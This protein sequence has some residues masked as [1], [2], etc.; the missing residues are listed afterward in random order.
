MHVNNSP[1]ALNNSPVECYASPEVIE[2]VLLKK[3]YMFTKI[4]NNDSVRLRELGDL[5]MEILSAKQDGYLPGLAFLDT[6]RGISPI[7]AKLSHSL[8]EKWVVQGSKFKADHNGLFPPFSFFAEFIC[9]EAR[10]RNDPS[11]TLRDINSKERPILRMMRVSLSPLKTSVV[12]DMRVENLER[13]CPIHNRPHSLKR[14]R[15]FRAK[16]IEERKSFLCENGICYK[17]CTSTTHLAKDCK[18][19][20][21]CNECES[22]LHVTVMHPGPPSQVPPQVS[23]IPREPRSRKRWQ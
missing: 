19:P 2:D 18:V 15:A 21:M 8:Q 17:C 20:V 6:A 7:V 4:S 10:I 23:Y 11:F 3:L 14:C 16:A 22:K 5:L 12:K 13:Y 9:C 1:I